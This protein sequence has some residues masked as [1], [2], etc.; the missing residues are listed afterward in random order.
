[1]GFGFSASFGAWFAHPDQEIWLIDGDGSFQMTQ[2][3]LSTAVQEGANV[4]IAIMNN[5]F[6]GMVRQW[7]EFFFDKRYASTPITGPDFLKL[8]EAHGIPAVRVTEPE[9]VTSAIEFARKTPGPVVLEFRVEEE[10]SVYPMVPSGAALDEMI[11][12]P[13]HLQP[14]AAAAD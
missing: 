3:E 6:L 4:K 10:E 12:R 11:R 7:Q 13:N 8:A 2:A 9:E 14:E 1:M 5:G